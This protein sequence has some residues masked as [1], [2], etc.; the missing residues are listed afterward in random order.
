MPDHSLE[1]FGVRRDP[2]GL[3]RRN[4]DADIRDTS[5][6]SA[7]TADDSENR[8]SNAPGVIEGA[9]DVGTDIVLKASSADG[10]HENRIS[11]LKPAYFE[12]RRKHCRPAFIVGTGREFRDIVR[13]SIGLDSRELSEI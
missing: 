6:I 5:C 2:F 4:D 8:G 12:P 1:R 10:K 3:N 13:W 9:H 7:I 11:C